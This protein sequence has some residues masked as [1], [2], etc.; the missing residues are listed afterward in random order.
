M[1]AAL[2]RY[3]ASRGAT[4]AFFLSTPQT[5]V[6]SIAVT[7]S[8]LGPLFAVFRPLL[9]LIT[10]VIGG[11]LVDRFDHEEPEPEKDLSTEDEPG[12]KTVATE[13]DN[14][15]G[16]CCHAEPEGGPF[17]RIIHF[18]LV[19]LPRSLAAPLLIGV[20]IAGAISAM[21]P[22]D[23]LEPY[24]GGGLLPMFV[25][26]A[27]GA[28]LYVCATAS[29]PLAVGFIHAGV[30]PGA[31]LVFLIVGPATNAATLAAL[32]KVLGRRAALIYFLVVVISAVLAGLA[33]D[34]LID[35]TGT[36]VGM[37]HADHGEAVSGWNNVWAVLMLVVLLYSLMTRYFHRKK[38]MPCCQEE[39]HSCH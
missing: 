26:M 22:V 36:T 33:F 18:A 11:A 12:E 20:I 38:A 7:Y 39:S 16:S 17:R 4:T 10:G 5:G 31:A 32:W 34:Q 24:L 9:A 30:S 3:G 25:M 19:D 14:E 37:A 6:D 35:W 23:V 29:V 28:P 8:L 13:G 1:S 2:R 27:V 15:P 21:V